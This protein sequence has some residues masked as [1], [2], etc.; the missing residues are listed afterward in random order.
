M[1]TMSYQQLLAITEEI[2]AINLTDDHAR[3]GDLLQRRASV[4]A[5]LK[6]RRNPQASAPVTADRAEGAAEEAVSI[7]R[8]IQESERR[9]Q[10]QAIRMLATIKAELGEIRKGRKLKRAYGDS[11]VWGTA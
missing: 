6:G 7:I 8:R 3:L 4:F 9:C 1:R 2:E 11:S 10:A 5:T